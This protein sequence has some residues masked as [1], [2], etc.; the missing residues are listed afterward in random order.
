MTRA[1]GVQDCV[2]PHEAKGLCNA[3]YLRMRSGADL[4]EAIRVPM[5]AKDR[6]WAKVDKRGEDDCW[7]W[8]GTTTVDHYGSF[9][10]EGKTLRAHRVSYTW[11]LGRIPDGM[12]VD[13]KCHQPSCVNPG[14]LRLATNALNSQNRAGAHQNSGSGVRGVAW[15]KKSSRW[16]AYGHLA[17]KQYHIGY[18]DSTQEAALAAIEWRREHMP[19]SLMDRERKAS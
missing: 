4:S 1:C 11:A 19:Y 2:R 12:Q 3:H 17:G 8:V 18:F 14:H 6:F 7:I 15:H 16:R 9:S 10:H 13:H 5:S